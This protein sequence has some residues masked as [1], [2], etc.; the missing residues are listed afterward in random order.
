MAK[1]LAHKYNVTLI[2]AS[3]VRIFSEKPA[4]VNDELRA[5][6]EEIV[7]ISQ[8]AYAS[9]DGIHLVTGAAAFNLEV[10][11]ISSKGDLMLLTMVDGTKATFNTK[12]VGLEIN[13][14]AVSEEGD[15]DD[16]GD[17]E[18]EEEEDIPVKGKKPAAKRGKAAPVEEDDEEDGDE[19]DGDGDDA[20]EEDEEDD[21]PVKGKKAAPA[22]KAT[23]A[24]K[25]APAKK[26]KA[27]ADDEDDF[28][29]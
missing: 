24:K 19:E 5:F 22:K 4:K 20:D 7:H 23:P 6:G 15:G 25:G 13:I 3:A 8:L 17:E 1:T 29:W 2:A 16:E 9:T 14:N 10:A 12:A 11:N 28:N 26:G 27:A 21:I 18:D